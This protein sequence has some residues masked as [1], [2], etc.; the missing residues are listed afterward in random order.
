MEFDYLGQNFRRRT[1]VPPFLIL[2]FKFRWPFKGSFILIVLIRQ[3]GN[4][5]IQLWII[6]K[7]WLKSYVRQFWNLFGPFCIIFR[8][9]FIV[10]DHI[11]SIA[12]RQTVGVINFQMPQT[13]F[14]FIRYTKFLKSNVIVLISTGC[15]KKRGIKDVCLLC[16]LLCRVGI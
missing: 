8:C 4:V 13:P 7:I 9:N 12:F 15:P 16:L 11:N 3:F 14:L 2:T 5:S 1:S 6:F 10:A